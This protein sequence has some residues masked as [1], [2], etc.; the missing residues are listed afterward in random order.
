MALDKQREDKVDLSMFVLDVLRYDIEQIDSII[1][2]LNDDGCIGWRHRRAFD[3]TVQEVATELKKL[4]QEKLVETY[5]R[6][7]DNS[8]LL[9]VDCD[10]I[11]VDAKVN[12][13]W[14]LITNLGRE[15]WNDWE[16]PLEDE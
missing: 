1:K 16:P 10:N 4:V 14:Y 15:T 8:E 13:Y 11:D 5:G 7:S 2:L 6:S 12:E 3:F 9:P